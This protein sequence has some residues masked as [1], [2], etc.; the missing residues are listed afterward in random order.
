MANVIGPSFPV[1][2]TAPP[3]VARASLAQRR[4]FWGAVSTFAIEAKERELRKGLDRFGNPMVA[5]AQITIKKRKSA[6]G[7]AH[8]YAPPLTPAYKLSRTRS[9]FTADV[10]DRATGVICW[11]L[12]DAITGASWGEILD[13]HRQGSARLPVRD[14]IGLAPQSLARI[15]QQALAWW[16]AH[17]PGVPVAPAVPAEYVEWISPATGK[18]YRIKVTP[19][20]PRPTGVEPGVVEPLPPSRGQAA[21]LP[22]ETGIPR[23][24]PARYTEVQTFRIGGHTY[25]LQGGMVLKPPGPSPAFGRAVPVPKLPKP[26]PRPLPPQP[27]PRPTIAPVSAARDIQADS[28]RIGRYAK[29]VFEAIDKI[30]N[31]GNLGKLPVKSNNDPNYEG[32]LRVNNQTNLPTVMEINQDADTPH[33]TIAHETGHVLDYAGIPRTARL[34]GLERNFR[35]EELFQDF[36]KAVEAS[37]SIKTLRLRATQTTAH[38]EGAAWLNNYT[39]DQKHVAYLLQDNEI[40]ARAYSQWV[41]TR[42]ENLDMAAQLEYVLGQ[43]RQKL[44][45]PQWHPEDFKPIAAAIDGIFQGLGWLK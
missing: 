30:H 3:G 33:I 34:I 44:Y 29:A 18:T 31:D 42:S 24:R 2:I 27:A 38:T 10:N 37:D 4:A 12:Y 36:I 41:A 20:G 5:L 35:D 43:N 6:V 16:I 17:P 40:W 19:G 23:T 1:A 9:L 22:S 15:Q 14:V 32:F 21:P 13:Y 39:I 28:P 45:A 26:K 11:W 7:P 25:T 8:A